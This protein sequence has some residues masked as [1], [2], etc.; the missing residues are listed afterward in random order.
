MVASNYS[1]SEKITATAAV[2]KT[3][4][5]SSYGVSIDKS[6]HTYMDTAAVLPMA[7]GHEVVIVV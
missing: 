1:A 2:M 7:F 6:T 4:C 5:S 3:S